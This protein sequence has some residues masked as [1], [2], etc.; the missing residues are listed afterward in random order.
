[1]GLFSFL[2]SKKEKEKK[3]KGT[4]SEFVDSKFASFD[5][6][7]GTAT[8][9]A[10]TKDDGSG[11]GETQEALVQQEPH[12][13]PLKD[14]EQ[15]AT[16]PKADINSNDNSNINNSS[17]ISS[18]STNVNT[19]TN[20]NTNHK[21]KTAVTTTDPK[22]NNLTTTPDSKDDPKREKTQEEMDEEEAYATLTYLAL[23]TCLYLP[24]LLFLWIRRSV[25][26]ATSLIRSLFLGHL[27]RLF[28]AFLLLPPS[29]TQSFLPVWLW[30]LGV[31]I[32]TKARKFWNS[33]LV[34]R[35]VPSWVHGVVALLFLDADLVHSDGHNNG[36]NG[37]GGHGGGRKQG[38]GSSSAKEN[39][40]TWP[41][42]ALMGLAIF[43]LLAFVVHP[44]GLTWM[45]FGQ[46]R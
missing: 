44:D 25:F 32:K 6:T 23:L 35:N 5:Q 30:N 7:Y 17:I 20:T 2:N 40:D 14:V 46:V 27:L 24:L 38:P 31:R 28:L 26:G 37:G 22:N 4:I 15:D 18:A 9:A 12:E 19:N 21:E 33:S 34:Q 45:I 13:S 43:T 39:K 8:S 41:P 11:G 16:V 36:H 29:T 1:M 3:K 42:P 10:T